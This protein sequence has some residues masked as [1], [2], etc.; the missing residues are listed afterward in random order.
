MYLS[1]NI[2]LLEEEL[3]GKVTNVIGVTILVV[4]I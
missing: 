4:V 1:I 3:T 2:I